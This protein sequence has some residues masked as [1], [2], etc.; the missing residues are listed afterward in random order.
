M[1]ADAIECT[2]R[3]AAFVRLVD[4]EMKREEIKSPVNFKQHQCKNAPGGRH[5][6]TDTFGAQKAHSLTTDDDV[7][8]TQRSEDSDVDKT[9]RAVT[10]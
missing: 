8:A 7:Q 3:N 5:E 2:R 4:H 10:L 9:W 6:S 1:A